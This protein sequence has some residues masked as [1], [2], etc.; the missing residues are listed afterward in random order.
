MFVQ[1]TH[2]TSTMLHCGVFLCCIVVQCEITQ[3]H[4]HEGRR[5]AKGQSV[6]VTAETLHVT[7]GEAHS[8]LR[9]VTQRG[10]IGLFTRPQSEVSGWLAGSQR[11]SRALLLRMGV[12]KVDRRL[13]ALMDM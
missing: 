7:W 12:I 10:G 8:T 6:A 1:N 5:D 3:S 2:V 13:P 4:N 9:G 11:Q